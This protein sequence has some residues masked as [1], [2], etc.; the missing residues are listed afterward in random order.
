M[1]QYYDESVSERSGR[2]Y[3]Y[4]PGYLSV[5]SKQTAYNQGIIRFFRP[6]DLLKA[7]GRSLKLFSETE[8]FAKKWI[9]QIH[10][11]HHHTVHKIWTAAK[12][13]CSYRH[14]SHEVITTACRQYWEITVCTHYNRFRFSNRYSHH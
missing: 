3:P 14:C 6:G 10:E 11:A 13:L 1:P 5:Q 7:W 12:Y 4:F 8:S 9:L 2:S